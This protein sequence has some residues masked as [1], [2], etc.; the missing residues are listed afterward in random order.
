MLK[1]HFLRLPRKPTW[2][3]TPMTRSVV[4]A[5]SAVTQQHDLRGRNLASP[6][7]LSPHYLTCSSP[8]DCQ[9]SAFF[10]FGVSVTGSIH[11]PHTTFFWRVP[12]VV[13]E[14]EPPSI[15]NIRLP[16]WSSEGPDELAQ[17]QSNPWL[18]E[19]RSVFRRINPE[20]ART[21]SHR[22]SYSASRG[23]SEVDISIFA[24]DFSS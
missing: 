15:C 20:G 5:I 24:Y 8:P 1:D 22:G 18:H 17:E 6:I 7:H 19:L 10:R 14:F 3:L 2:D 9:P 11:Y 21:R 16:P 13:C 4:L 23:E 12:T